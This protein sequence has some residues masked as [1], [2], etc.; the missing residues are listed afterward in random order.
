MKAR[1]FELQ[2]SQNNSGHEYAEN[3]KGS[4]F[5]FK[6]STTVAVFFKTCDI[7]LGLRLLYDEYKYFGCV[8]SLLFESLTETKL[9]FPI[10]NSRK[11]FSS[12]A[13]KIFTSWEVP[14]TK[15]MQKFKLWGLL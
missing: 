8:H 4:D 13:T 15:Y 9:H 5:K 6:I 3:Q 1:K 14:S 2:V 10:K 7:V 12:V 11:T